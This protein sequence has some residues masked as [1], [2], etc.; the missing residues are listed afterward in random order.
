MWIVI[1]IIAAVLVLIWAVRT[2]LVRAHLRGHGKDPGFENTRAEGRYPINGGG[3][4]Y[5]EKTHSYDD[6]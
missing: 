3:Y 6:D 1:Y 4:Y 2:P 5:G